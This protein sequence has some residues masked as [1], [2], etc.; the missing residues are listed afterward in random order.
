[1]ELE[2]VG[3]EAAGADNGQ[4]GGSNLV[5]VILFSFALIAVLI[6]TVKIYLSE[7]PEQKR[8]TERR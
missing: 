6:Y 7:S 2:L 1:M 3:Q 4:D 8:E 5:Y